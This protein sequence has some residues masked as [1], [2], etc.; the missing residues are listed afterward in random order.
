MKRISFFIIIIAL[1]LP[2]TLRADD[3]L[4]YIV[5]NQVGY[6]P[7]DPK[8]AVLIS[9]SAPSDMTFNVVDTA[10]GASVFSGTFA[11]DKGASNDQYQHTYA[12]DFSSVTA[13][14]QYR[15]DAAGA[16][17]LPFQIATADALYGPL[18][19]NA[20]LFYQAQRD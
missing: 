1:M 8:T 18:L 19:D 2:L 16:S 14:G 5:V 12:L 9:E 17:S 10:S 13:P 20:L 7:D 11:D 6:A 4:A 15:I 3:G